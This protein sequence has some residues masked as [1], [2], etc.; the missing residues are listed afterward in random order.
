MSALDLS[1]QAQV[2]NLLLGLQK[3]LS[4][5]YLFIS[6]DLAVVR[7]MSD[8][9]VVLYRGQVMEVGEAETVYET[10]GH[11]YSQMLI[12]AIPTPDPDEQRKRRDSRIALG[13]SGSVVT[14]T[15]VGCSFASR[16]PYAMDICTTEVPLAQQGPSGALVACHRR[17]EVAVSPSPN[18]DLSQR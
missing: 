13:G 4:L 10:P 6:H 12:A 14:G 18:P 3:D 17:D 5:S 11:P 1:I 9:I 7:H 16:C 2:L 15:A 8:R